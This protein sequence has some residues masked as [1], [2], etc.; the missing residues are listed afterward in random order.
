MWMMPSLIVG[1]LAQSVPDDALH[2]WRQMRQQYSVSDGELVLE[3]SR[4]GVRRTEFSVNGQ[5]IRVVQHFPPNQPIPHGNNPGIRPPPNADRATCIND[6]YGFL[7][8]MESGTD[9]WK[10]VGS[11]AA[12]ALGLLTTARGEWTQYVWA[13]FAV[14]EVPLDELLQRQ[15]CTIV[16]FAPSSG[17]EPN[18]YDL[19]FNYAP[20]KGDRGAM[21]AYLKSGKLL[22]NKSK[23]WCVVQGHLVLAQD[24]KEVATDYTVEYVDSDA[25]IP[26]V[27]QVRRKSSIKGVSEKVASI[28]KLEFHNLPRDYFTLTAFGLQERTDNEMLAESKHLGRYMLLVGGALLVLVAMVVRFVG[29]RPSRKVIATS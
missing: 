4:G 14:M 16:H 7:L 22:L 29:K 28:A 13:P 25:R 6:K 20:S 8:T 19:E 23:S 5:M 3:G 9:R 27:R 18:L 11:E 12:P 1:A 10:L 17:E 15:Q 21:S 2:S 26:V 24:G